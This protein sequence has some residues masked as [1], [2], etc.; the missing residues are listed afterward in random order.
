MPM[1][2]VQPVQ[3]RRDDQ[4]GKRRKVRDQRDDDGQQLRVGQIELEKIQQ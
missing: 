1:P 4:A 2:M 3:Q